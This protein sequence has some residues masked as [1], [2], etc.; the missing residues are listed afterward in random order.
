MKFSQVFLIIIITVRAAGLGTTIRS[1]I[2]LAS[3]IRLCQTHAS[4]TNMYNIVKDLMKAVP[5]LA[6]RM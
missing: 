4:Q 1:L 6:D 3:L 2:Y 5:N